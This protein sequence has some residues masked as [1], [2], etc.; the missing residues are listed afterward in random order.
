MV[1]EEDCSCTEYMDEHWTALMVQSKDGKANRTLLCNVYIVDMRAPQDRAERTDHAAS[2]S[3][4]QQLNVQEELIQAEACG[5]KTRARPGEGHL[6]EAVRDEHKA[7]QLMFPSW[8]ACSVEGKVSGAPEVLCFR[9]W[10]A[11]K[12]DGLLFHELQEFRPHDQ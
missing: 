12:A 3:S 10:C 5:L 7:T 11:R 1:F 4:V 2:S 9:S 6:S 8:C